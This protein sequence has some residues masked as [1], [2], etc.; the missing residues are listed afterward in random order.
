MVALFNLVLLVLHVGGVKAELG[1]ERLA[2]TL[3]FVKNSLLGVVLLF[4]QLGVPPSGLL[5]LPF[6]T[7]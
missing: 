1:G 5:H 2:D 7:V 3:P 4:A 6:L